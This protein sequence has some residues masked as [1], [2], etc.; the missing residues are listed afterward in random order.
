MPLSRSLVWLLAGQTHWLCPGER[1]FRAGD[2]LSLRSGTGNSGG[3]HGGQR[4]G[5][6]ARHQ[7]LRRRFLWK[8]PEKWRLWRWIR[9]EP[10]PAESPE[11]TDMIPGGWCDGGGTAARQRA[12]WSRRVSIRLSKAVLKMAE[13]TEIAGNRR[14]DGLSGGARQRP[15]RYLE[16]QRCWQEAT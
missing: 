13:E 14:A 7:C 10:S 16:R 8:R 12:R 1:D 4:N 11:V 6:Q 15:D 3:D 5:S 9:P 2:Q